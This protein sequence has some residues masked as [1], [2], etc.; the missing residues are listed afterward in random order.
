MAVFCAMVALA[1]LRSS[2]PVPGSGALRGLAAIR[3]PAEAYTPS[4][5][6]EAYNYS[7]LYTAGIDGAGQTVALIE[8]DGFDPADIA[9]FD[10]KFGLAPPSIAQTYVGGRAFSLG[11]AGETAL[12]IEW[13]HALAPGALIRVYYVNNA[14]SVKGAW[15][16]VA[17]ALLAARADGAAAVSISLG[18]CGAGKAATPTRKALATL[19]R[20]GVSVFVSSGDFGEHPG[21][22]RDCGN[23]LGLSYPGSDPSVVAVGGTSLQLGTDS[24]IQAEVAWKRSGGGRAAALGRAPWQDAAG[25]PRDG[26][27]WGPDVAFLAN[28]STGVQYVFAGLWRQTGGTSLGAPAWAA[29]WLLVRQS[30]GRAGRSLRAAAPLLYRIAAAPGRVQALHDITSGSNGAYSAHI[31]WD[32]V[33]G[34]GTPNVAGLA[35]A[36]ATLPRRGR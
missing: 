13:F 11:T 8:V 12:D 20:A 22:V 16:G 34:W 30:A 26:V 35:Q 19:E 36:A 21:P 24:S 29:A 3:A 5:I 15:A 17:K 10:A 4:Q 31:G 1:S 25:L 9:T 14:V 7:S 18:T 27:R 32:A 23:R 6:A 2:P 33:T 28:P